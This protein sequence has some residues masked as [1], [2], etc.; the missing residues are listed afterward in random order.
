[1]VCRCWI[2]TIISYSN[3]S[4]RPLHNIWSSLWITIGSKMVGWKINKQRHNEENLN[5]ELCEAIFRTRRC[6]STSLFISFE[7]CICSLYLWS[8]YANIVPNRICWTSKHVYLRKDIICILL[9][10]TTDDGKCVKWLG[11]ES[12]YACSF[13]NDILWLLYA[14]K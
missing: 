12:T 2:V 11:I 1:M 3:L 10:E 7:Y 5:L 8:R 13:G 9:Q 14:W 4:F 6:P